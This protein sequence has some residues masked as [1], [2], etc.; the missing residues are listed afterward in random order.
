[1]RGT[2]NCRWGKGMA[3]RVI[4]TGFGR[5]G[6]D[7][8]REALDLLGFGPCHHMRSLLADP[9]QKRLWRS[10]A[11][12]GTPGWDVILEGFGACVDWPSAHYWP[13]L[14]AA[15]PDAKVILTWRTPGS[16]WRSFERTILPFILNDPETE[17][18]APGSQL[19]SLR[20][21]GGLPPT[22]ETC[23]AAY[24]ANVARVL[25]EVPP[26]RLLVHRLG[27][28]WAPLCRHLCVPVPDR[29][30]PRSNAAEE[31]LAGPGVNPARRG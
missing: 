27:D 8:M 17:E 13:E 23:I 1:M 31:F 4:G 25:A 11:A 12:T 5:T 3:L 30:Y 14:V 26:G 28:G 15:F 18:S 6:T 9:E 29:P 21:F 24:E 7:S 16:W 10:R 19:L 22:R 20:V 2:N